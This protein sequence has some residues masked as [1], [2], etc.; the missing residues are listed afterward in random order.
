MIVLLLGLAFAPRLDASSLMSRL[1]ASRFCSYNLVWC[2]V[3]SLLFG[4]AQDLVL[5][6]LVGCKALFEGVGA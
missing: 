6:F 5:L 2:L 1:L 3:F 4:C